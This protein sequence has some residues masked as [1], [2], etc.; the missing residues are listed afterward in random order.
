MTGVHI[1]CVIVMSMYVGSILLLAGL[2]FAQLPLECCALLAVPG[3]DFV[4]D[5]FASIP[6]DGKKRSM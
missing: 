6:R 2:M 5:D 4:V 1:L 3:E